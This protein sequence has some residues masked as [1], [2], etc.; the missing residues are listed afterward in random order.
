M[1]ILI[2]LLCIVFLFLT[3][4]HA[5][6]LLFTSN[7]SFVV[8]VGVTA[9]KVLV[10]GGGGGGACGHQGGGGSGYVASNLINVI[11]G[12]SISITVGTGGAGGTTNGSTSSNGTSSSF[13][14]YLTANGGYGT[15]YSG[16]NGGSGGGGAGNSGYGGAGGTGGLNGYSGAW[17]GGG[18]G[19][20]NYTS[21]LSIFLENTFTAGSGGAGGTSSHGGGGGGGGIL[22]NGTGIYGTNGA[23]S[24]SGKGGYGYGSGG[25]AGGY[26]STWSPQYAWGGAGANGLVY[27]EYTASNVP[28]FSSWIFTTLGFLALTY[29][30]IFV[31]KNI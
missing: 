26:Q 18:T 6:S 27:V 13:G 1:R 10:V 9:V 16:G 23:M 28:E 2:L 14:S 25:G 11:S 30:Q 29:F 3:P 19:Q 31:K 15:Q 4:S 5:D 7:G 12:Q 20:G 21:L 24:T 22:F 8:P 17:T